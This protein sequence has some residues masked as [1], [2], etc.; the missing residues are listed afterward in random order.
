MAKIVPKNNVELQKM[1]DA[2]K[3]AARVLDMITPHVAPGVD[4][5]KLNRLCH[6]F[7]VE[8]NAVPAP[9]NYKGFP[10]S[11]C[12]SANEVVCHGI[13]SADHVLK[14]GDILNIDVTVIL[15]GYHGDT[16]RMFWAGDVSDE[17]KKLTKVTYDCMWAGI[18]TVKSGSRVSEIGK[19]IQ[20]LAD[21]Y[22]Y[23][24]V[25]DFCGH[26]L[27]SKFHEEPAV[28]H[29][30][31]QPMFGD[32]RLRK[33]ATLTIE[34]MINTGTWECEVLEDDWTAV[35]CDGGLSA[36][37]EHSLAVTEDGFEIFTESLEGLDHPAL[38]K[39]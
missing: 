22:N 33:G 37:F 4:T 11:I 30:A 39:K 8:H 36:Q 5:E 25:R 23:G 35:T 16:S 19:A 10:K 28:L 32:A 26:G 24:V 34:P 7:I 9:L 1:R 14:D 15:N 3:L 6:D 29:Y 31:P 2:G 12:T 27:G 20:K 21:R 38:Y 13:P 18:N 17:A